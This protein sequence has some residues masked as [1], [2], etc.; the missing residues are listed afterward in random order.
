MSYLVR[1]HVDYAVEIGLQGIPMADC[2]T[3]PE[4][5]FFDVLALTN[6]II[7]LFEKQARY[8]NRAAA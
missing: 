7:H 6:A 3:I 4:L 8:L 5:Y 1:E 2:K